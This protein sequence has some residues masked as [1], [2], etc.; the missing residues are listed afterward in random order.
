MLAQ[1]VGKPTPAGWTAAATDAN[2]DGQTTAFD[3]LVILS[4]IVGK[5]VSG[6]CVATRR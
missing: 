6:F 5:D 4:R 1:V 2:C 3:V